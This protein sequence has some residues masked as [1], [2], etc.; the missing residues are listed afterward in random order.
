MLPAI[1][2][3]GEVENNRL[4]TGTRGAGEEWNKEGMGRKELGR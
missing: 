3:Y 2:G 4:A 1:L